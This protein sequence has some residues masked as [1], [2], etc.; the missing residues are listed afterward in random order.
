MALTR[1][2]IVAGAGI[3][4]LTASLT[5]AEQ[6]FRVVVLE[7]AER[8][9]Q[10]GAGIQLSPNA[11]RI[12]VELGLKERLAP[13]AVTPES[14]NIMS[15]R[16]G[17]E[18]ARMPLGEAA[19][20]RAGA[21]YWVI[22]RA[23]LQAVLQAAVNDHP[24]I[25]LRLGCQFDD[26]SKHANGLMVVQRRGNARQQE[27]A[28]ALIGADGIWSSVRGHLFPD[29]QPRFSGLIAWRGTLEAS[30]LPREYTTPHV[31][32]W[33]GPDAHLVAYP[34]SA[35]R[36]IN[37]VAITAGA[38]NQPGWS[39][40]GDTDEI[41][42]AFAMS[43]WPSTARMLVGAVGCW[44]KWALFTLPDLGRW[45]EG[46]MA[47]LGDAAHAM[48]PFAAQGA[49][50]A[51]E[52]AAVLARALSDSTG[53][54]ISEIPAALARYTRMR[55]ARVLQVQRL[56]RQQGRIYHL[57]GAAAIARDLALRAMGPHRMLAR[58]DW[59]YDWCL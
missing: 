52:D 37:V 40:P 33:M 18:I 48:L 43:R 23:D 9:E 44:R 29:I 59:I 53:E 4:G 21:P 7:R 54:N 22:H 39:A 11:S 16:A 31:Q 10:A 25:D 8:L 35:G 30:A 24:D 14:V 42:G 2:V 3:G 38:W 36:Q 5:L 6:G 58:Q 47:L 1:T 45:N 13:R 26:V 55:R 19:A 15:A 49:G 27:L 41:K 12:L 50:M 32:L 57:S 34:I 56:A 51:I 20:F 46:A 28:V 17:G